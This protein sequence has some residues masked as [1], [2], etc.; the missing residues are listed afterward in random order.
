VEW[1]PRGAELTQET[2]KSFNWLFSALDGAPAEGVPARI[3]AIYDDG[4]E[5]WIQLARGDDEMNTI[6]LRL[7]RFASAVHASAALTRWSS[8]E[9]SSTRV[10]CAMCLV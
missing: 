2:E 5:W 7:S 4:P 3:L 10:I 6:I 9:G 1:R 8:A